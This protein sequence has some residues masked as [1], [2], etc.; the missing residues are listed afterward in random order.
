MDIFDLH[1]NL[2]SDY[3]SYV[4]S[5]ITP[6]DKYIRDR[7]NEALENGE[8]WP[9]PMVSL[10]PAFEPG[11]TVAELANTG[12]LHPGCSSIFRF[13]KSREK[14]DGEVMRLHRHQTDAIAAARGR[15]NYVLTTGTGSGKSL[16]YIVPIVDHVLRVGS[17][18]GIQAIVVYPMNALAN[19][20][21]AELEKFLFDPLIEDKAQQRPP[22]RFARYTGQESS[23][24]KAEILADPPDIIL[25]N[26]V[27]LELILTRRDERKL[28]EAASDLRFLV[29]DELHTYRGRQGAD[30][31]LL[32]RRL[33]QA[34]GAPEL[35][36][37]GTSATMAS[38]GS[39]EDRQRTVADVASLLFGDTV[40]PEHVIGETL[41]RATPE[42][43][44]TD[45][46]QV[47]ALAERLR[48]GGEPPTNF[49]AFVVDPLSAWIEST[50]GLADDDSGRLARVTPKTIREAARALS[51]L[52]S[53]SSDERAEAAIQRQLLAGNQIPRP[54]SPNFNVF[55]FRLHQF[56]SRGDTVYTSLAPPGERVIR[57]RQERADPDDATTILFG[58]VFCRSCG[59]DYSTVHW[60]QGNDELVPRT[61]DDRQSADGRL[62]G[63]LYVSETDP[64]PAGEDD[65]IERVPEE[66]ID[67][68]RDPARVLPN[69]RKY[70]PQELR[71]E[72]TGAVGSG[73]RAWFVPSPFRFCLNCGVSYSGRRSEASKLA[74]LGSGG[75]SS[76]TTVMS[77]S[78][79]RWLREHLDDHDAAARKLLAF[80][81]NRQDSSLQAGHFN[82]FVQMMMLRAGLHAAVARAGDAGLRHDELAQRVFDALALDPIHYL[83]DREQ[84]YG[85]EDAGQALRSVLEY[86]LY[87]DFQQGFRFT[88]PNLEFTG[89]LRV[90][91]LNLDQLCADADDWHDTHLALLNASPEARA[92]LARVV[93]DWLRREV[94]IEVE[95]L[96]KNG[97][98]LLQRRAAEHLN[99][100]WQVG[101]GP[102]EI[103]EAGAV[104]LRPSRTGDDRRDTYVS[105]RG[106]LGRFVKRWATNR[107]LDKVTPDDT[108]TII[109]QLFDRLVLGGMVTRLA[110]VEPSF[111]LKAASMVWRVGD[112]DVQPQDTLRVSRA[113]EGGMPV[114]VYFR[115]AY[116]QL[117]ADLGELEAREH[118]AQVPQSLRQERE[119]RFRAGDLPVMYCSP[120]MELGVDIADLN[121]VGMRN[122]PPTPANYAQRSGRAGR[123]GQPAMV[124]TYCTSGSPH[125]QFY[126]RDPVRM[127]GGQVRAPRI[128]LANEDLVRSHIHAVW[129]ANGGLVLERSLKALLNLDRIAEPEPVLLESKAADID[130]APTDRATRAAAKAVMASV[131]EHLIDAPW[132]DEQWLDDVIASLPRQFRDACQRWWDLYSSALNLAETQDRIIRDHS[133]KGRDRSE[134]QL[135][136]KQAEQ[137]MLV[138][139]ATDSDVSQSDFHAYRYFASEGF[140]PGYSFPRLPVVAWVD[141]FGGRAHTTAEALQ[142]PRF[143]AINEFGPRALIY[144]EGRRHR[145]TRIDVPRVEQADGV[146]A[147]AATR[148]KRC[149]VCAHLHDTSSGQIVDLCE[150]CNSPLGDEMKS[151]LRLQKVHTMPVDRISSD[152]EERQRQGYEIISG[153]RFARRDGAVSRRRA[154]VTDADG[155]TLATLQFGD[156]ATLWRLN[157]G[158][159]RRKEKALHG[160]NLDIEKGRWATNQD[161]P[162]D[163]VDD[164]DDPLGNQVRRVIPY[165]EDTR[166]ML[167]LDPAEH[168]TDEQFASVQSALKR[169]IQARF[170]LEDNEL[171]VEPLP[172]TDERRFLLFY[173]SAEGGAGVL[174]LLI[175]RPDELAT[176]VAEAFRACH[177]DP[178]TGDD[179]LAQTVCSLACY[180]CLLSYTNQPDHQLLDRHAAL[181]ALFDW[182][183]CRVQ[184]LGEVAETADEFVN[185]Q[186]TEAESELERRFIQFLDDQRARIPVQGRRLDTMSTTPDFWFPDDQLLIYID[187]PVHDFPDRAK[188]DAAINEALR[189]A[190]WK[191]VRFGHDDDWFARLDEFAHYFGVD[192]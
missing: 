71:V 160:F 98:E 106:S 158:W 90:D 129:L 126:F 11:G 128:E 167:L 37:V 102:R 162:E 112:G 91:Y 86:R 77:I 153:Y 133:R 186:L 38:E 132:F 40:E 170:E 140:L 20:Q 180:D 66:W 108:A 53:L 57:M 34:C 59:Q 101:L 138:L 192:A 39:Y 47:A 176:V 5:F 172:S 78:T 131:E 159:R 33:R 136:R 168:W 127:V 134:A 121:V 35:R 42:F 119:D 187:G 46:A 125:D 76:A 151:L 26:Y 179:D 97:Q 82:D 19:S 55:A 80:S 1:Q 15:S 93:L 149:P 18:K 148:T 135:V 174:R 154:A 150:S 81:D 163:E 139:E 130:R 75:R 56:V 155:A 48:G 110:G 114:N 64:W 17:G 122:V 94:L 62:A 2:I 144:H 105:P 188:R 74:T 89:L 4:A 67:W 95:V 165:V 123:G 49:D 164:V 146:F 100:R 116:T 16:G 50:L 84:K 43:D 107:G 184:E 31:A 54:D 157:L 14:P 92:E 32:I 115:D 104:V 99:E 79:V 117:A 8:L 9:P 73:M 173:E 182:R 7:V 183:G 6:R 41:R 24:R 96:K 141:S 63:Y 72:R 12:Q 145:I 70:L 161:I 87:L 10:N 69:Y 166:N 27:M 169:A 181:T 152:E 51:E 171:A 29:L 30:V 13:G 3:R 28:V 88:Q 83:K 177:V 45:P 58:Q 21:E 143:L 109:R 178:E 156:A 142:R 60:E 120:T 103:F 185:E 61:L 44:A 113:P 191:V 25:T 65:E 23:E 175:D 147:V 189:E 36:C 22:V 85:R 124:F 111:R 118:T 190:G 137:Q 68:A 52:C